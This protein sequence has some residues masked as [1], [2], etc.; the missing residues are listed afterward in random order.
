MEDALAATK[1]NVNS[2]YEAWRALEEQYS[3]RAENNR[4]SEEAVPSVATKAFEA[5]PSAATRALEAPFQSNSNLV[6]IRII[7]GEAL[8]MELSFPAECPLMPMV[9]SE[10]TSKIAVKW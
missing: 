2:V 10:A 9:A 3:C 8:I 1:T 6:I 7:T 5:S 4:D